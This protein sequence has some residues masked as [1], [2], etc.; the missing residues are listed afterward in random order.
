MPKGIRNTIKNCDFTADKSMVARNEA[1]KDAEKTLAYDNGRPDY[2]PETVEFLKEMGINEDSTV[3]D[4]GCG[5]GLLSKLL[6]ADIG[7]NVKAIDISESMLK[8]AQSHLSN[9]SNIEFLM[10]DM[11]DTEIAEGSMDFVLYGS[12]IHWGLAT[13]PKGV[14]KELLRILKEAGKVAVFV[15][16]IGIDG[17]TY[18]TQSGPKGK[19][20]ASKRYKEIFI[21]AGFEYKCFYGKQKYNY[22][23]FLDLMC[24]RT[25]A[26]GKKD[27]KYDEFEKETRNLFAAKYEKEYGG[28][29][30]PLADANA[31]V[32][33][34][35]VTHAYWGGRDLVLKLLNTLEMKKGTKVV[36]GL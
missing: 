1:Y 7:C 15:C 29:Y 4:I 34:N 32:T 16:E 20:D 36:S 3:A 9:Y 2:P 27:P 33:L 35:P 10:K 14:Y 23:K 12:S 24:S 25:T 26:P 19:W 6:V 18:A 5:T 13:D 22:Q 11:K 30:D 21:N 17:Y 8:S 28:K 31:E